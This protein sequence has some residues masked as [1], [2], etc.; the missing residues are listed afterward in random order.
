MFE[1][2]KK[3][4]YI[5]EN[6]KNLMKHVNDHPEA[7]RA[8]TDEHRLRELTDWNKR[9]EKLQ[10]DLEEYLDKKR[11]LF[12]RF[13]FLASEELLEII[14]NSTVPSGISRNLKNL[15]EGIHDMR[16]SEQRPDDI[17]AVISAEG[18]ILNFH[19]PLRA[20]GNVEEWLNQLEDTVAKTLKREVKNE[21][22]EYN[23]KNRRDWV[24]E[25]YCQI[26]SLI[27]MTS[28]NFYTEDAIRSDDPYAL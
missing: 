2:A 24:L 18:E 28:W 15:F 1:K 26:T 9:M 21:Y 11:R 22:N 3:F 4:N 14:S 5:N 25:P 16:I 23:N 19:K 12:P 8:A 27:G 20:R 13:Y 6:F 10:K 17:E 7:L